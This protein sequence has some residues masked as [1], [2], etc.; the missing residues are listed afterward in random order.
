MARTKRLLRYW[1]TLRHLR[2][3]QIFWRPWFHFYRPKPNLRPA[4]STRWPS[5]AWQ[6]PA[7]RRP[8]LATPREFLLLNRRERLDE[9]GWDNPAIDKLWVYN[10]HYFDD[11]NA[12]GAD[13]RRDWHLALMLDWIAH[14]TPGHGS[15]WEPYPVSLRIVNWIKWSLGGGPLPIECVESLAVQSRWLTGRLE[16]HLLGNHLFTNAKALIFAGLFFEGSEAEKWLAKG[17]GII[18]AQLSEQILEDGGQFELSPMYHALALED[19]LDLVNIMR[20]HQATLSS[21]ASQCLQALEQR[22][23]A[24]V[25]WLKT[26]CHTDGEISFFNDAAMGSAPSPFELYQYASRLGHHSSEPLPAL[27]RLPD[28]G[29]ARMVAGEAMLL[30]DMAP[31][32]PDY[33]PGHAHAD[34]LSFELSLGGQRVLVNSGTSVYGSSAERL[35]Q[36]STAAHNCLVVAGCN[37]SDVWSG[38]RVGRRA[39]PVD[40]AVGE[41]NGRFYAEASHDGYRALR[42]APRHIRRWE[43]TSNMLIVEDTLS[44]PDLPAEAR[45]HFSP[46]ISVAAE[47]ADR[48][49]AILPDGTVLNWRT[50]GTTAIIETT[51]W[52]PEFGLAHPNQCLVLAA[53]QGQARFELSWN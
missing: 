33:L 20:S 44:V 1:H 28:S 48:G 40:V 9:I 8:S 51:S 21:A 39:Y 45:V 11:L 26:M 22:I 49:L 30:L 37:S 34:T 35:R 4:P 14:N 50:P 10:Q 18:N 53:C 12:H 25:R 13:N 16:W 43:F 31:V 36:R 38:F 7:K 52:H 2:P 15:G 32:G 42:G 46:A 17:I 24:M 27:V 3:V 6:I 5:G 29:Y 23:P 41:E 47:G 19:V